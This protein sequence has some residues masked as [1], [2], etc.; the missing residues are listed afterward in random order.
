MKMYGEKF[1]NIPIELT[2]SRVQF[3]CKDQSKVSITKFIYINLKVL[4]L[5]KDYKYI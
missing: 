1:T 4:Q 2:H 3:N 5:K